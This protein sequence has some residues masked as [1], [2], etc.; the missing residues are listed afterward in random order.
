MRLLIN[1]TIHLMAIKLE[2][3]YMSKTPKWPFFEK[4]KDFLVI[5]ETLTITEIFSR[6]IQCLKWV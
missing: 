1:F 4:S 6:E 2:K 5:A 3:D